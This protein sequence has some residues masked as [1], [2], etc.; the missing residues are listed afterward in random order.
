[1]QT[2]YAPPRLR[3]YR[4]CR[5]INQSRQSDY[6]VR[7]S[8][9]RLPINTDCVGFIHIKISIGKLFFNWTSCF[10]S[11]TSP[12]ILKT[13]SVTIKVR[14]NFPTF[15]QADFSNVHNHYD[16]NGKTHTGSNGCRQSYWRERI[17][18]PKSNFSS[19]SKQANTEIGV[20]AAV[21]Q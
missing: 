2:A 18:L 21:E 3:L 9:I 5:P 14:S 20:I 6:P 11:A 10:K 19:S 7:Q 17:Y 13:D 12:S 16:D 1:M 8:P 4:K 15:F